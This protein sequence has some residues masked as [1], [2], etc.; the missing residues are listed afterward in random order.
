MRKIIILPFTGQDIKDS[1][2]HYKDQR[3]GLDKQF[4]KII[5][6]A[7]RIISE[8]P[9]SFPIIKKRIRKFVIKDFPF[10]IFYLSDEEVIYILAVFHNKR[11]P[12]GWKSRRK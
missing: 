1:V 9:A 7:F 5:D 11:N 6:Q 4:L 10:C 12:G 2:N 3:E 8:N